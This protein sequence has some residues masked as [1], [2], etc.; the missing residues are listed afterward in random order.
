[1]WP[2]ALPKK[3]DFN[4][5]SPYGER[6]PCGV[7]HLLQSIFQSTLPLRG[8]TEYLEA[9]FEASEFQSTLPLRGA[10]WAMPP[11]RFLLPYFNPRSPYGER[12]LP[13]L[14]RSSGTLFQSTLPL[15]GAT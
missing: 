6:L 8:A 9:L 4:P 14:M 11:I 15:R 5:R 2:S 3:P 12:R 13:F 7:S 10:T 1:M